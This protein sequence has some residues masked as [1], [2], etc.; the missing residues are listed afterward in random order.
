MAVNDVLQPD[1][2]RNTGSGRHILVIRLSAMGDVAMTVPVLLALTQTYPDLK[3]TVLTRAFF[4]PMFRDI[5]NVAIHGADVAGHHKGIMGLWKLFAEL[6]ALQPDGVADL[7]NVLRSNVLKPFFKASGIPF[8][9]VDKGRPQKRALTA[10]RGKAIAPLETSHERYAAVF[11]KL[12]FPISLKLVKL[13]PRL[14]LSETI[15]S[16]AGQRALKWIGIAPFAAFEGKTYPPALMEEVIDQLAAS[17][18]Y[19]IF[20]LG[21]GPEEGRK[22]ADWEGRWPHCIA[23]PGKF[24]F[25]DE[26]GL[27]SNLDLMVSMDSGNGHLA[28]MFGIPTITLWGVTHPY[29][30]FA[31]FAADPENSLL[32]DRQKFPLIPT[33]VYGNKL[34]EG[35]QKAMETIRPEAILRKIDAVLYAEGYSIR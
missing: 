13:L 3:V 26:L 2:H 12:G 15:T 20:L 18:K 32:A 17:D 25:G 30:G 31:P 29:A 27:I 10:A 7:H 35:Y 16:L 24:N 33:S 28:A 11:G 23:I 9:Q 34:P 21:G 19:T 6:K 22:L 14:P 1:S 5:S 4:H 8:V